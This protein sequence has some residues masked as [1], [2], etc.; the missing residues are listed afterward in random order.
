MSCQK[1]CTAVHVFMGLE[2]WGMGGEG[3]HLTTYQES[4]RNEKGSKPLLYMC[5]SI[6]LTLPLKSYCKEGVKGLIY[7]HGNTPRLVDHFSEGALMFSYWV[8][9]GQGNQ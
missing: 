6:P 7:T 4:P 1:Q 3:W 2:S 8:W 5:D 9:D